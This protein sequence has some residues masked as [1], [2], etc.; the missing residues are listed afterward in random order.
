MGLALG[1]VAGSKWRSR[2]RV[3]SDACSWVRVKW[4]RGN[5]RRTRLSRSLKFASHL[6]SLNHYSHRPNRY[7]TSFSSKT[8]ATEFNR[9]KQ[10]QHNRQY[11][12]LYLRL[13]CCFRRCIGSG[14]FIIISMIHVEQITDFHPGLFLC[15][16][17][18][19]RPGSPDHLPHPD[20]LSRCRY[21]HA[22]C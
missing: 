3:S 16:F 9:S 13:R 17:I 12:R 20:Q 14:M 4:S 19:H 6:A 7:L 18:V 11:A 8:I 2:A 1:L 15:P 5:K 22:R 21:W 10:T